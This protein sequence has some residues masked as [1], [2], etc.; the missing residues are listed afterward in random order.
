MSPLLPHGRAPALRAGLL[1]VPWGNASGWSRVSVGYDAQCH[2]RMADGSRSHLSFRN[3]RC[4]CKG[5]I[6]SG[7][8]TCKKKK[9]RFLMTHQSRLP[10]CFYLFYLFFSFYRLHSWGGH[11]CTVHAPTT[12]PTLGRGGRASPAMATTTATD[13]PHART[14]QPL[15]PRFLLGC[16]PIAVPWFMHRRGVPG[17]QGGCNAPSG[18]ARVKAGGGGYSCKSLGSRRYC[19]CS[20]KRWDFPSPASARNPLCFSESIFREASGHEC[21]CSGTRR[22]RSDMA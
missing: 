8:S 22:G 16:D 1:P 11:C 13:L 10:F 18:R 20:A 7:S 14:S 12:L 15:P 17:G 19:C 21:A 6:F 5:K 2:L 3:T 4:L 9:K